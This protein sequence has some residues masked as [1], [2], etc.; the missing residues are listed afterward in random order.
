MFR[1]LIVEDNPA[2]AQMLQ[3]ALE[4]AGRPLQIVLRE[5]GVKAV[6]YLTD[7][8]PCKCDLVLL[9]LNLPRLSGF[10]VLERIRSNEELQSLPVV[11]MSGSADA[12]DV[13]RCYR[14][15]ANSYICKRTHLVDILTVAA[16]IVTYW[17][18]CVKL[19]SGS[20]ARSSAHGSIS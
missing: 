20:P 17:S 7:G 9:D 13:N 16:Q 5:D 14:A 3:M 1:I 6:E 4:R 12:G 18:Q 15:G 2:D 11:V 19:P 10:E 8:N